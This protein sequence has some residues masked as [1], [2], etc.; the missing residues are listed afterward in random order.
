MPPRIYAACLASY[1]NGALHGVWI[2]ADQ[3]PES[4]TEKIRL[5]LR[6]SPYPTTT[7]RECTCYEC[8][9]VWQIPIDSYPRTY[10]E[11]PDCG[12]L[13]R[14]LNISR[15]ILTAEEWAFH[16]HEGWTFHDHEGWT[17]GEFESIESVSRAGILLEQHGEAFGLWLDYMTS[18]Q[19]PDEWGSDFEDSY[20]GKFA[21]KGDYA[22]QLLEDTGAEVPEWL[23]YYIDRAA[24]ERDMALNGD[25]HR[26]EHN[27][28]IYVFDNC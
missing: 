6:E 14:C 9:H 17:P 4:I 19:D 27:G 23:E 25:I 5:M 24:F 1:N 2:D 12:T 28:S 21:A 13:P 20:L 11:C 18:G 26:V 8:N 10:P 15:P 16:D 3:D 7:V 22:A